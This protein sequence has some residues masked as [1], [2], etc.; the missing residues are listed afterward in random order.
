MAGH[1]TAPV[2][3]LFKFILGFKILYS[4]LDMPKEY[5][6]YKLFFPIIR[7]WIGNVG[8]RLIEWVGRAVQLDK[9]TIDNPRDRTST[10]L[11]DMM[12]AFSQSFQFLRTIHWQDE[13]LDAFIES[14]LSLCVSAV[15]LYTE[16]LT[17]KMLSYFPP[18]V[19]MEY[20]D[21]P[22]LFVGF[23]PDLKRLTGTD[24]TPSQIFVIINNFM[25]LRPIWLRFTEDVA[26]WFPHFHV[27]QHFQNPVP[28]VSA[29]SKAIPSLFAAVTAE[30][31]TAGITPHVWVKNSSVKTAL[32][33]RASKHILN[34]LFERRRSDLFV[35]LFDKTVD[36]LKIKIDALERSIA[37]P[38]YRLMLH[39]FLHGLDTGL[40]NVVV[41]LGDA[42]PIKRKRFVTLLQ[43][44]QDVLNDIKEYIIQKG[45]A[46]FTDVM[47]AEGTP[48]TLYLIDAINADFRKLI[49]DDPRDANLTLGMLNYYIIAA[50]TDNT[51]ATKWANDQRPR[52]VGRKFYVS[53]KPRLA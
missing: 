43:F 12:T 52:Y 16:Q 1:R 39:G 41:S 53:M 50:H 37:G 32:L 48:L 40:M 11:I 46:E 33:K 23:I 45:S 44:F 28:Q 13:S 6:P 2:Q 49:E 18:Q 19:I 10:S 42:R 31:T 7:D 17:L 27:D 24:I 21:N 29:I 5:D 4:F 22:S 38:N 34:P 51:V 30:E 3:D 15:R 25:A 20:R 14:F 47:F 26:G 36:F 8:D 35:Q 9:F